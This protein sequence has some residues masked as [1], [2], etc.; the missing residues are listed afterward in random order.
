MFAGVYWYIY[1]I[2]NRGSV[3]SARDILDG[4]SPRRIN[5]L[6]RGSHRKHIRCSPGT[7]VSLICLNNETSPPLGGCSR[8]EG[9]RREHET[10]PGRKRPVNE[11]QCIRHRSEERRFAYLMKRTTYSGLKFLPFRYVPA[12]L[13]ALSLLTLLLC[14]VK[15]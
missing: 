3:I 12:K 5:F 9:T 7:A 2:E 4:K 14:Q 10:A 8:A 15:I 13:S 1:K 11:N 6:E